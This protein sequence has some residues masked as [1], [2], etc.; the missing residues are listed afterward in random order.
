ML[1]LLFWF[2]ALLPGAW[3]ARRM[4]PELWQ[5]EWIGRAALAALGT[6]ALL[7]P[8]TLI[9][10]LVG[11]PLWLFSA[12]LVVAIIG[13]VALWLR[14]TPWRRWRRPS[15]VALLGAAGFAAVAILSL[16]SGGYLSGDGLIHAT[17]VRRLLDLGLTNADPY[18]TPALFSPIYH[19][20][21]WHTFLA[22]SAQLTGATALD[23][24]L[25]ALP[26]A[27]L[28]IAGSFY[29]VAWALFRESWVAWC[30]AA[31]A[32]VAYGPAAIA[33]Y[34]NKLAPLFGM[35][36]T[37][38]LLAVALRSDATRRNLLPLAAAVLVCASMHGL[39]AI[40][41]VTLLAPIGIGVALGRVRR[42]EAGVPQALLATALLL[43]GLAYPALSAALTPTAADVPGFQPLARVAEVDPTPTKERG[44]THY[45]NGWK[46]RTLALS[47]L[48]VNRDDQ[49]RFHRPAFYFWA[50]VV[51]VVFL[52]RAG[53]RDIAWLT[54]SSLGVL[55]LILYLP[56]LYTFFY[57]TLGSSWV[58][59][60]AEIWRPILFGAVALPALAL[61]ARPG[62]RLLFDRKIEDAPTLALAPVLVAALL[63][64]FFASY[65]FPSRWQ[66]QLERAKSY[67][68]NSNFSLAQAATET[69][70]FVLGQI[71][72]GETVLVKWQMGH[73][74]AAAID[75]RL[76][77]PQKG[78]RAIP[79]FGVRR[80][81]R[82]RMLAPET[83]WPER[84]ALLQKYNVRWV[85]PDGL[86][87]IR[88]WVARHAKNKESGSIPKHGRNFYVVE[89]DVGE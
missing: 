55:T 36:T 73:I 9:G 58:V 72:A 62:L 29:L 47:P 38:A 33:L 32:L 63:S 16:R 67:R 88:A 64:F 34:P 28:I 7:L 69:G 53:R 12:L 6:L 8:P 87:D 49:L 74:L 11:A 24:W 10:Y 44:V 46:A 1:L 30:A 66:D 43:P 19:S 54:G 65:G 13:G 70:E 14:E 77:A 75:M 68:D 51:A 20:N 52:L 21:I 37:L 86:E 45:S 50:L 42:G 78:N 25:T 79:D 41:L 83:P 39:Y 76:V 26:L 17:Y 84:R 89:L 3:L 22:G 23:T 48:R 81:D 59:H 85:I 18:V 27:Q 40:F 31:F 82:D 5:G 4:T 57:N 60:R 61:L 56:P 71:D 2:L 15:W 35:T 80:R